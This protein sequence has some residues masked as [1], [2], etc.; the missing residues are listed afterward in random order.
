MASSDAAAESLLNTAKACCILLAAQFWSN[1]ITLFFFAAVTLH[2]I[3]H[4]EKSLT[5]VFEYL[6]R[7][8]KQYMDDCGGILAMNNVKVNSSFL[9]CMLWIPARFSRVSVDKGMSRI[10]LIFSLLSTTTFANSLLKCL[11]LGKQ[12]LFREIYMNLLL[13]IANMWINVPL[14]KLNRNWVQW[15][16]EYW[17]GPIFR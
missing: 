15:G 8:L 2:D 12:S 1:L 9:F 7:D 6:E 11:Y 16:S 5:L 14:V 10:G 4:T 17:T 13:T 3:V